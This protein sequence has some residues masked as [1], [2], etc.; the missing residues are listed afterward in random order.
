VDSCW[1]VKVPVIAWLSPSEDRLGRRARLLSWRS[2]EQVDH[3][4]GIQGVEQVLIG[5][6]K[7]LAPHSLGSLRIPGLDELDHP[8]VGLGALMRGTANTRGADILGDPRPV[9]QLDDVMSSGRCERKSRW[10]P[11]H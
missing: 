6:N 7:V 4:F 10:S 11:Y 5:L 9:G 8:A 3:R 1:T 2:A